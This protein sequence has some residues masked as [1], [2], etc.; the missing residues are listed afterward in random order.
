MNR[1]AAA[2]AGY[3]SDR[4]RQIFG[5]GEEGG[6]GGGRETASCVGVCV[7]CSVAHFI[8]APHSGCT[9][10]CPPPIVT[11]EQSSV[12]VSKWCSEN[13]VIFFIS[14]CYI[15]HHPLS[16]RRAHIPPSPPPLSSLGATVLC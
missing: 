14:P 5:Q 13:H 6:R 15:H 10:T 16:E 1:S 7:S 8:W 12:C 2:A 9:R 4:P 11:R 3:G